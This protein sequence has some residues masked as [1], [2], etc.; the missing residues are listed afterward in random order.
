MAIDNPF[1]KETVNDKLNRALSPVSRKLIDLA[2]KL[3]G[4][5]ISLLRIREF[6]LEPFAGRTSDVFGHSEKDL[7]LDLIGNVIVRYPFSNIEIFDILKQVDQ[8]SFELKTTAF[9]VNEVLPIQIIIPF[10]GKYI[11]DPNVI[12]V[13]DLIVDIKYDEHKNKIPVIMEVKKVQ[14]TF[15]GKHLVKRVADLSLFRSGLPTSIRLKV[16]E[17]VDSVTF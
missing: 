17:Y 8:T 14:G 6:S 13:K 2:T 16:K 10:D 12:A 7:K 4:T 15:M 3:Y 5:K 1:Y 11:Q 9:D